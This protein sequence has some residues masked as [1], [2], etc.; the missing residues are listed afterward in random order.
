MRE[1]LTKTC[2]DCEKTNCVI[3]KVFKNISF[4]LST[5]LI[6]IVLC[7]MLSYMAG[8][9]IKVFSLDE[10]NAR[11]VTFICGLIYGNLCHVLIIYRSGKI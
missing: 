6:H 1:E 7:T 9:I 2:K 11:M 8:S 3:N 10:T 5:L 4:Y